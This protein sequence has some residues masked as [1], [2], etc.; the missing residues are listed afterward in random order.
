MVYTKEEEEELVN[1]S[2]N[3]SIPACVQFLARNGRAENNRR[4]SDKLL[5]DRSNLLF[6]RA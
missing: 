3:V 4:P 1:T 6:V 5:F 2:F